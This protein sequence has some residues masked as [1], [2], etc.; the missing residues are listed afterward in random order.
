[1]QQIFEHNQKILENPPT[2]KS[3]QKFSLMNTTNNTYFS[4]YSLS[5]LK[6]HF[7]ENPLHLSTHIIQIAVT[8]VGNI[9]E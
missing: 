5:A 6:K 9:D 8:N 2:L 7:D 1:M 4:I 3:T